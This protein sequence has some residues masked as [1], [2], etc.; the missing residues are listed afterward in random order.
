VWTQ[1]HAV[2]KLHVPTA[3]Q[4]AVARWDC[5]YGSVPRPTD[6]SEQPMH[7]FVALSG[8]V[9]GTPAG[10]A[11]AADGL[12]AADVAD[13]DVGLTVARSPLYAWHEPAPASAAAEP[14]YLD[15][16]VHEFTVRLLP[17]VPDA[18]APVPSVVSAAATDLVTPVYVL[19][20]GAHPGRLPA[21]GSFAQVTDGTAALTVVKRPED[22]TLAETVVR[23]FETS[24]APTTAHLRLGGRTVQVRL[25]PHELRTLR[26]PDDPRD[27]PL[28]VD[29]CEWTEDERPPVQCLPGEES[30]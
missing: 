9:E 5:A 23:V 14:R 28:D 12:S 3:L 1:P 10:L 8:Q 20:E 24:G 22:P 11:V 29:L 19:R 16:G 18:G 13:G 6:G 26:V 7:G 27:P 15:M 4:G 17:F 21:T 25:G 30:A 2:L